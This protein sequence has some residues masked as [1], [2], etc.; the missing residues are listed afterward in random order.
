[1]EL[2]IILPGPQ[3]FR[4]QKTNGEKSNF[5]R[6][7]QTSLLDC[8]LAGTA[9]VIFGILVVFGLELGALAHEQPDAWR[10]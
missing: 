2:T 1:M 8:Q 9:L 7:G 3:M 5:S 6:V 10:N 4:P